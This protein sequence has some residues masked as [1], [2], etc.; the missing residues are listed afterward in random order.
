MRKL[1]LS[2]EV[3]SELST[4]EMTA[5]VGAT[6][7]GLKTRFCPTDPCITPPVSQLRCSYSLSPEVCGG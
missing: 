6:V 5:V 3:L 4:D 2:K 7:G 1:H